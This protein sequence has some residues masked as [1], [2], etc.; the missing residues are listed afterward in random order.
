MLGRDPGRLK[1]RPASLVTEHSK[2]PRRGFGSLTVATAF[3]CVNFSHFL[4]VH[5]DLI[6]LRCSLSCRSSQ[7]LR[8]SRLDPFHLDSRSFSLLSSMRAELSK[9]AEDKWSDVDVG[10]NSAIWEERMI[11]S[12]FMISPTQ[13]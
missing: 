4:K 11:N 10:Y 6:P 3:P 7:T 1:V 5:A 9:S 2:S 13:H 12:V 8:S